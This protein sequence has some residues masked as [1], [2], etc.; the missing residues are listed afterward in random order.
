MEN[1][2]AIQLPNGFQLV[3]EKNPDNNFSREFFIGITDEDGVWWQD[4]A[5]VRSA[6]EIGND[7]KPN[8]KDDKFDVLVYSD[9]HNEDYTHEFTVGL[10]KNDGRTCDRVSGPGAIG[11]QYLPS[12]PR[13]KWDDNG[14]AY[15]CTETGKIVSHMDGYTGVCNHCVRNADCK[16]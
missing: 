11:S 4:L 1:R 6:Y 9:E 7:L 12:C 5:V 13:I 3:V 16:K 15:W 8:W 2:I 10:Y 14:M